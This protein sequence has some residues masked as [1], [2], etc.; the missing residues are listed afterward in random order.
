MS[1]T[2]SCAVALGEP[3]PSRN[4]SRRRTFKGAPPFQSLTP[5]DAPVTVI[6]DYAHHPSEVA[7]TLAAAKLHFKGQRVV[8]VFRPH[9][10]S[11]T[12][13]LLDQYQTAFTAADKIYNTDIESAREE[14]TS[15]TVTG[16][17]V[18]A[19]AGPH[20]QY[21][22]TRNELVASVHANA[23]PGDV[24]VCMTVSGYDGLAEELASMHRRTA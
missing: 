7:A 22:P 9:T 17:D 6:D 20:A 8:A 11:R 10:Y 24:I 13:A 16:A 5:P 3:Q 12:A 1:K 2:T 4:H 18:A 14:G 15:H 19:Q 23:K 21:T